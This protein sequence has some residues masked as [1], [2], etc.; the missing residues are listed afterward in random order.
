MSGHVLP[1]EWTHGSGAA[2]WPRDAQLRL[3]DAVDALPARHDCPGLAECF[4][5]P[6]WTVLPMD[7]AGWRSD[8]WG[9]IPPH[10]IWPVAYYPTQP[11]A[12]DYAA[13]RARADQLA[14]IQDGAR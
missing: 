14:A 9:V 12:M 2:D 1:V 11:E 7:V 10:R 3:L 4:D 13:G 8:R 6:R 5:H